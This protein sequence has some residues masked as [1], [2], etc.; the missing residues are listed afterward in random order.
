M[1]HEQNKLCITVYGLFYTRLM[2]RIRIFYLIAMPL[3]VKLSAKISVYSIQECNR[4]LS[5][6]RIYAKNFRH[7]INLFLLSH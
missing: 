1:S 6:S 3:I 4:F 2:I 7:K 5:I